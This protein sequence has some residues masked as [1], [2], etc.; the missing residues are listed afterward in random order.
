[1]F[2]GD[3][4]IKPVLISIAVNERVA[5]SASPRIGE[6]GEPWNEVE[7]EALR[8]PLS[9]WVVAFMREEEVGADI[10]GSF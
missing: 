4:P 1:L 7:E 3:E 10:T 8:F 9:F 5:G 2:K 6:A